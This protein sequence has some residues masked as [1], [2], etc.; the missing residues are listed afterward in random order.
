M[1]PPAPGQHLDGEGER[2][3]LLLPVPQRL[4]TPVAH[5]DVEH[6][7]AARAPGEDAEVGEVAALREPA[8]D[9]VDARG[10]AVGP[11]AL[12]RVLARGGARAPVADASV[13][14]IAH[15]ND[16]P[17]ASSCGDG[18]GRQGCGVR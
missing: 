3:Q 8:V 12:E 14:G 2:P 9:S 11:A 17:P 13:R 1:P 7:Q 16:R 18:L 10:A 6:D 5:V 4:V 15:R